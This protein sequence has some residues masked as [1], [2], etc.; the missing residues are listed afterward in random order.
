MR[1]ILLALSI[2]LLLLFPIV[3]AMGVGAAFPGDEL[4]FH[5][6][7]ANQYDIYTLDVRSGIQR[8]LFPHLVSSA[9]PLWSPDGERVAFS[10][11]QPGLYLADA[12]GSQMQLLSEMVTSP[13]WSPDGTRIAYVRGRAIYMRDIHAPDREPDMLRPAGLQNYYA[14]D[15]SP[16]GRRMAYV[17]MPQSVG[18]P[19][20]HILD[21]DTGDSTWLVAGESP[22]WSPDGTRIA[23]LISQHRIMVIP[24][25][26]GAPTYIADGFDQAW[27]PDGQ[28]LAFSR[29]RSFTIELILRH[30]A[31]G[32][33]ITLVGNGQAI[34]GAN[35]RPR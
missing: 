13:T 10:A 18:V 4:T 35:W 12:A 6:Y 24:S 28:W 25:Q 1:C 14:V 30:V 26:G 17:T 16:D 5:V 33:E 11:R 2:S 19:N 31:S 9:Y 3:G 34:F 15:W 8:K 7:R 21:L 20:I 22:E 32:K 29:Q 23:Y 27:S